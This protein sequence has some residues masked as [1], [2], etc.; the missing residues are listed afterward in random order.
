MSKKNSEKKDLSLGMKIP[1]KSN[2]HYFF[3][4]YF[5]IVLLLALGVIVS[6]ENNDYVSR[7]DDLRATGAQ[8]KFVSAEPLIGPLPDLDYEGINWMVVGGE[9]G[10]GCRVMEEQWALDILDNCQECN[11][12]YF[13]KQ[14]GGVNKKKAGRLLQGK[15]YDEMP[16]AVYEYSQGTDVTV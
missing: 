13:F 11:V 14:W 2:L 4:G 15:T 10:P 12:P 8:V 3:Y 16:L 5:S 9:S 6:I 7:A 1:V